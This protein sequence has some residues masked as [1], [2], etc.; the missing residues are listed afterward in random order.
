MISSVLLV[1]RG[2]ILGC[3]MNCQYLIPYQAVLYNVL[4]NNTT[5][6]ASVNVASNISYTP[7]VSPEWASPE[8]SCGKKKPI[9][10][11]T[12]YFFCFNSTVVTQNYIRVLSTD[13]T[14]PYLW[15]KDGCTA[16]FGSCLSA[17]QTPMHHSCKKSLKIPCKRV[18]R[19][20]RHKT[21]EF[22]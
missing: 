6:K 11:N 7:R 9:I 17:H 14:M 20:R 12:G 8:Y 22:T 21:G 1:S 5:I 15:R 18:T 2:Y 4:Y 16:T 10:S 3:K 13:R 19:P